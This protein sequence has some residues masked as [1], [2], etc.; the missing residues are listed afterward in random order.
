MSTQQLTSVK[1]DT[2]LFREFKILCIRTKFSL[3]K[4][5]DRSIHLFNTDENFRK[6]ILNHNH[7]EFPKSTKSE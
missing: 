2:E 1:V 5:N 6:M 3:Q 7:L 4:L